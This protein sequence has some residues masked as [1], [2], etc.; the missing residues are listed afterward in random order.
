MGIHILAKMGNPDSPDIWF[1]SVI[2]NQIWESLNILKNPKTLPHTKC[3]IKEKKH[4]HTQTNTKRRQ[5]SNVHPLLW[6]MICIIGDDT[7]DS[8]RCA[9]I[10]T[11]TKRLKTKASYWGVLW[12]VSSLVF[13]DLFHFTLKLIDDKIDTF[14]SFIVFDIMLSRHVLKVIVGS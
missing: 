11:I 4:T 3:H 5:C 13:N 9:N 10:D 14:K 7:K 6:W 2:C 12:K 8:R 1:P